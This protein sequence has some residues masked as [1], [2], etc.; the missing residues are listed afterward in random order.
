MY[1]FL[2]PP[3]QSIKAVWEACFQMRDY[4]RGVRAR[5]ARARLFTALSAVSRVKRERGT[6]ALNLLPRSCASYISMFRR[7]ALYEGFRILHRS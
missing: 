6:R 5:G 3:G 7:S 2:S 4:R 1:S